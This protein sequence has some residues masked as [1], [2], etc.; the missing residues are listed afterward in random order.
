LRCGAGNNF[1]AF[2]N[3][4]NTIIK[5]ENTRRCLGR[6]AVGLVALTMIWFGLISALFLGQGDVFILN[7]WSS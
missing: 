5:N 3:K 6:L 4:I 7:K 2:G 1:Y